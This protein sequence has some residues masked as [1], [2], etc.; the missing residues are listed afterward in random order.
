MP[1]RSF[2]VGVDSAVWPIKSMIGD[3]AALTIEAN[4]L[5]MASLMQAPRSVIPQSSE[6]LSPPLEP[7]CPPL[8]GGA[9]VGCGMQSSLVHGV[10]AVVLGVDGV[11]PIW[12]GKQL[13]GVGVPVGSGNGTVG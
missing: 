8:F 2:R 9:V 4:A 11:Q 13:V 1:G 3:S 7:G 5:L 12:P 10:V 6:L